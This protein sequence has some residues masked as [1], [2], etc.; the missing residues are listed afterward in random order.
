MNLG[1]G[2]WLKKIEPVGGKVNYQKIA[3]G[4]EDRPKEGLTKMSLL[5]P[6]DEVVMVA[7]LD[8]CILAT[9]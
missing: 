7:I 2:H 4:P 8:L 1:L 9:M 3:A 5:W 6:F